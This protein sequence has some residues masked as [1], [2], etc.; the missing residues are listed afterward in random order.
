MTAGT[1]ITIRLD[2]TNFDY[3]SKTGA[4]MTVTW[5]SAVTSYILGD[6]NGDGIVDAIDATLIQRYDAQM[7]VGDSFDVNAADVNGDGEVDI[8]DVTFIQ[9]YLAGMNVKFPIGEPANVA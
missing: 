3:N 4:K 1:T 9:R 8:L 7:H 5:G 2:L 6:A